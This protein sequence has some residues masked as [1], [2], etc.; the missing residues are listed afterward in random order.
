MTDEAFVYNGFSPEGPVDGVE[1][2]N[3]ISEFI[4]RFVVLPSDDAADLLAMWVLHTHAFEAAFA[5]PYLRI[6][7]A[8]PSS[9]KTLLLEVL[10]SVVRNGWHA[11]NPSVAVLYRKIDRA[12]PSLLLDEMDNYPLDDRRDARRGRRRA[13]ACPSPARSGGSRQARSAQRRACGALVGPAGDRRARD[14]VDVGAL[15]PQDL[16]AQEGPG[17]GVH[18]RRARLGAGQ[19]QRGHVGDL[20]APDGDPYLHVAVLGGDHVTGDLPAVRRP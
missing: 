20:P 15:R 3:E 4:R 11:I 8:A 16:V 7:S 12:A 13:P 2:L 9:G 18:L 5:T 10:A 6:T 14:A 1:L 19:R 17:R